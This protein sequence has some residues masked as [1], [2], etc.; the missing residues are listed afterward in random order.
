MKRQR[1]VRV[2]GRDLPVVEVL[3]YQAAGMPARAVMDGDRE[4]VVV[5]RGGGWTFWTAEDRL[6]VPYSG[7]TTGGRSDERVRG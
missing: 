7:R 6:G 5:K 1:T 4:R 2:E 3:P